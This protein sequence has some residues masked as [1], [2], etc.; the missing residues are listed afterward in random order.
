[1]CAYLFICTCTYTRIFI[2]TYRRRKR[3]KDCLYGFWQLDFNARNNFYIATAD[4]SD[5]FQ[6]T[7]LGVRV[8]ILL[9][10]RVIAI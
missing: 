10:I 7:Y 3:E 9:S 2:W 8:Y 4:E 1:M 5:K 6:N